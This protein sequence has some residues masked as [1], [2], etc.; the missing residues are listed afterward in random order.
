MN[1]VCGVYEFGAYCTGVSRKTVQDVC[2]IN[3]N[4]NNRIPQNLHVIN[5]LVH[6]LQISWKDRQNV[7]IRLCITASFTNINIIIINH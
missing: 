2:I 6:F 4:A 5:G 3:M 1:V 7:N